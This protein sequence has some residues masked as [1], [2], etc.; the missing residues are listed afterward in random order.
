MSYSWFNSEVIY[1]D[2]LGKYEIVIIK[3]TPTK[4]KKHSLFQLK[5]LDAFLNV[6]LN[7]LQGF[8]VGDFLVASD[9]AVSLPFSCSV[10]PIWSVQSSE[11]WISEVL[12]QLMFVKHFEDIKLY[13]S[14]NVEEKPDLI[15]FLSRRYFQIC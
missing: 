4:W 12:M 10:V 2:N 6:L 13:V 14:T 11:A 15:T 1:K 5:H 3:K 7:V 8:L 9:V